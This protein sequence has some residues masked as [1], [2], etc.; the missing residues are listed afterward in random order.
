MVYQETYLGKHSSSL[1]FSQQIKF[2]QLKFR[3]VNI[4]LIVTMFYLEKIF[5]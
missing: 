2:I 1:L 5:I 4:C 3:E